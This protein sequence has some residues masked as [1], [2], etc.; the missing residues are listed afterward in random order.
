MRKG[1]NLF[2][3]EEAIWEEESLKYL[4]PKY[5][6]FAKYFKLGE[7]ELN[8]DYY[9]HE[10]GKVKIPLTSVVY[11]KDEHEL[12]VEQIFNPQQ[13]TSILSCGENLEDPFVKYDLVRLGVITYPH[14]TQLYLGIN[15]KAD[16]VFYQEDGAIRDEFSLIEDNIFEF[17]SKLK[18]VENAYQINQTNY[19]EFVK[20]WGKSEWTKIKQSN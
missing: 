4:P 19:N 1:L 15:N 14:N 8:I 12:F 3:S 6:E 5:L 7:S 11:Q 9:I 10:T 2:K 18:L 13:I 16:K 17:A 20:E